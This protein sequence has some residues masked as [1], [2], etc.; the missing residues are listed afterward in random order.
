MRCLLT[1]WAPRDRRARSFSDLGTWFAPERWSPYD[2]I[3]ALLSLVV[4]FSVFAPW[5]KATVRI[6]GT[7]VSGSLIEPRGTAS[8]I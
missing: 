4:A 8:G 7:S 6:K 1:S 2:A 5:F 3:V